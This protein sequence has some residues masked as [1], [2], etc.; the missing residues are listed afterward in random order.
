MEKEETRKERREEKTKIRKTEGK[1][2][3]KEGLGNN[4]TYLNFIYY[5]HFS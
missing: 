5:I 4:A 3:G 1:D 2:K